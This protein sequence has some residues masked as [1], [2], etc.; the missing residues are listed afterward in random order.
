MRLSLSEW[1]ACAVGCLMPDELYKPS[2]EG[3]RISILAGLMRWLPRCGVLSVVLMEHESLLAQLQILHDH[4]R[5]NAWA[6]GLRAIAGVYRLSDRVVLEHEHKAGAGAE[7]TRTAAPCA[8]RKPALY[9]V[10]SLEKTGL[11]DVV[12]Y[13]ETA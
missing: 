1:G 8:L 9:V 10:K 4:G 12:D 11:P 5:P 13:L 3:I 2:W 7:R 6:Q